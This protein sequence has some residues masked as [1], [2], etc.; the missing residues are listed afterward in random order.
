M[1]RLEWQALSLCQVV[2]NLGWL[3]SPQQR[4]PVDTCAMVAVCASCPVA[5]PCR[6]FAE[7]LGL[8]YG[9]WA[10]RDRE[11]EPDL[12]GSRHHT[13]WSPDDRQ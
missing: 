9:F 6:E 11:E 5:R 1:M 10:G 3:R 7:Q 8:T 4:S 2:P 12:S 13:H